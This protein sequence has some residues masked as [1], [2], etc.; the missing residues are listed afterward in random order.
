MCVCVCLCVCTRSIS[1]LC[2]FFLLWRKKQRTWTFKFCSSF[3]LLCYC[4]LL[5]HAKSTYGFWA[6][7][8]RQRRRLRKPFV[9]RQRKK[10][11]NFFCILAWGWQQRYSCRRSSRRQCDVGARSSCSRTTA[12]HGLYVC[13]C[14]LVV[15]NQQDRLVIVK[16]WEILPKNI[17]KKVLIAG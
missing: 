6:C 14:G 2:L 17:C 12:C 5:S 1:D 7:R 15:A 13:F 4:W 3:L 10:W 9:W 11:S 8:S 16:R